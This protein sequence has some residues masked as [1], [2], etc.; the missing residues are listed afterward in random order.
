MAEVLPKTARSQE[1]EN[2]GSKQ[3]RQNVE[4]VRHGIGS[5][6]GSM[7]QWTDRKIDNAAMNIGDAVF[8][9]IEVG[10][11]TSVAR[12]WNWKTDDATPSKKIS[13]NRIF[14]SRRL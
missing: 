6:I 2:L 11:K 12:L 9:G 1:D 5:T 10:I 14:F 4:S 13:N 8:D 7:M 3:S